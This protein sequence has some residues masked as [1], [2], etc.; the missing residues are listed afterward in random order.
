MG[1]SNREIL[2]IALPSIAQNVTVPLLGLVD[3]AISGHLGGAEYIGAV[4]V[5]SMVFNMLYWLCAFLRMS[6]GGLTAQAWGR[7]LAGGETA[8]AGN[9]SGSDIMQILF[10]ALRIGLV[11]SLML[12]LLQ[13][14][15][16]DVS[17]WLMGATT[18]V[19]SLGRIYFR[20]LIWGAPAVLMT[21]GLSGWFL[22]RQDAKRPMAIAIVQNVI[23]IALSL[24]FVIV[25][26]WKVEGVATG[27]LIAQWS[28]VF[29]YLMCRVRK[30]GEGEDTERLWQ[31]VFRDFRWKPEKEPSL[32]R[33]GG[34]AL[35]R[36]LFM[37]TL[38]MV[39]VQVAF[40]HAGAVQGNLILASNALLMQ[41]YMFFS[42]FMDGFAYAGE[43]VGGKY[44]GAKD[45]KSF[46]AITR[47]LFVWGAWLTVGFTIIYYWGGDAIVAILT[48]DMQVRKAAA[49][50]MPYVLLLPLCGMAA[51]L[52]DGL[53]AGATK[54]MLMFLSVLAGAAVFFLILYIS[55]RSGNVSATNHCLWAAMLSF[56]A[57]RSM[58][59]AV[60]Y[61]KILPC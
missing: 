1:K 30:G 47:G 13:R 28:A 58:F 25:V 43:A 39:C 5:G 17:F 49:G 26:G 37:R 19:E 54:S 60:T 18:E 8:V 32:A 48:D 7:A 2:R 16:A 52:F 33:S 55:S 3:A 40:T 20:I 53:Y 44:V 11:I 15:L 51:F 21:Y 50:F 34:F 10:R 22:G 14:P 6:T 38:C 9:K 4:A 35:E 56:L 61:R 36:T 45:R 59:L 24:F 57:V 27:T 41:F 42:Y 46:I 31:V 29:M 12:L 23:N